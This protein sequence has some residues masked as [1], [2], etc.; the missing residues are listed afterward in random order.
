MRIYESGLD[1]V[2]V[3]SL[4]EQMMLSGDIKHFPACLLSLT[5][6]LN[7]MQPPTTLLF[8]EDDSGIWFA[9]EPATWDFGTLNL[10][11][12]DG[13]R[14]SR[15]VLRAIN[16]A[17]HHCFTK[18][19][20]V[21]VYTLDPKLMQEYVHFGL[22]LRGLLPKIADGKDAYLLTLTAEQFASSQAPALLGAN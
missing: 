15:A 22:E 19:A 2:R 11:V 8:E 14:H 4:W 10:W 1:D 6:F 7:T 12:R 21:M 13:M 20:M 3:H 5:T 16:L 17:L 9:I 18:V